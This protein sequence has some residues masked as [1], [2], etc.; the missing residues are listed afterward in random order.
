MCFKSNRKLHSKLV[1]G[2]TYMAESFTLHNC[3]CRTFVVSSF[4]QIPDE[5]DTMRLDCISAI[6]I[7]RKKHQQT[8]Q[9]AY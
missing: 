7:N 5:L 2:V 3:L 4:Y 8:F 9:T 1:G 6:A